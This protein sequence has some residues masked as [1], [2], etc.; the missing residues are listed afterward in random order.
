[1]RERTVLI[2]RGNR[3]MATLLGEQ[4][5]A[6]ANVAAEAASSVSAPMVVDMS[7]E[8][9]GT[10]AEQC[11]FTD[12]KAVRQ[13]AAADH[14]VVGALQL[15]LRSLQSDLEKQVRSTVTHAGHAVE[16]CPVQSRE[17]V[18]AEAKNMGK[19]LQHRIR[20]TFASLEAQATQARQALT[21]EF[22]DALAVALH[23]AEQ[24]HATDK[25]TAVAGLQAQV[26]ELTKQRDDARK[27][28]TFVLLVRYTHTAC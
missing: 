2:F 17:A 13:Q 1:M 27:L 25:M 28:A 19:A 4:A 21:T 24:A 7:H 18:A 6:L 10:Q 15:E 12:I 22:Q 14:A 11:D 23:A 3:A 9:K 16:H 5:A 20:A 8:S 26:A